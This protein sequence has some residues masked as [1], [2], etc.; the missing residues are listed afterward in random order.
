MESQ[1]HF[2]DTILVEK[3]THTETTPLTLGGSIAPPSQDPH[4]EVNS[5]DVIR[6]TILDTIPEKGNSTPLPPTEIRTGEDSDER[7]SEKLRRTYKR[8]KKLVK[9]LRKQLKK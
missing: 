6:N 3:S 8:L 5:E 1:D 9:Y 2:G 4:I 7:R